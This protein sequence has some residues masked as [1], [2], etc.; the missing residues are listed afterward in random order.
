MDFLLLPFMTQPKWQGY[1]WHCIHWI[2][3]DF[4]VLSPCHYVLCGAREEASIWIG[5]RTFWPYH[6]P[7]SKFVDGRRYL[8]INERGTV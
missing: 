6:L 7:I 4:G 8:S 5:R 2:W 1:D 3:E